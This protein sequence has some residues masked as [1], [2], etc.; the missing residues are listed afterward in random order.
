[1]RGKSGAE[2][3]RRLAFAKKAGKGAAKRGGGGRQAKIIYFFSQ[4]NKNRI[5]GRAH[6]WYNK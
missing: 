4:K 2:H 5:D 6:R 3:L 1:M